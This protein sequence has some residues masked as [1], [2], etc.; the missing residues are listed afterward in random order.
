MFVHRIFPVIA[1]EK[2]QATPH[3]TNSINLFL[4]KKK[5]VLFSL[6]MFIEF[7]RKREKKR[8]TGKEKKDK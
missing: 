5:E 4:K 1:V 7:W 2:P 6:K 3:L 8:L